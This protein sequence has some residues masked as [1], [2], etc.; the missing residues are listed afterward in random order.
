[1]LRQSRSQPLVMVIAL[2]SYSVDQPYRLLNL[3]RTLAH[4][5]ESGQ[6]WMTT[7]GAICDYVTALPAD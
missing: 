4:I 5:V 6:A 2:H 3:R 1:M 7:P